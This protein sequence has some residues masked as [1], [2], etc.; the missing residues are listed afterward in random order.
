MPERLIARPF[1][2]PPTAELR[3]LP[4]CPRQLRD[5]RLGWVAI[6]HG[7]EST[8]GSF[9][10]LDLSTLE[11]RTFPLPGRPGFFVETEE[12]DVLLIGLERR[13][14]LFDWKSG[15]V[16]RT[17][18]AIPDDPQVIINDGIAV[19]DGVIFGT[20]HLMFNRPVAALY[21][22]GSELRELIGEQTCSN[23]KYFHDDLLIDVDTQPKTI[24]EYRYRSDGPLEKLRFVVPPEQL[25]ALPDG[26]RATADGEYIVVAFYNPAMVADGI[27]QQIRIADG[28]VVAEWSVPG[29][30]RVTCPA[31]VEIGGER[32]W[33]FTTAVE[34]MK[35]E[36][37]QA[38][39]FFVADV[40]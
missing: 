17:I 39:T 27:V 8:I 4:E 7:P 30:P 12:P 35:P 34:G 11:N 1:F 23:G 14:V 18:A 16:T 33:L 24:T 38:G 13:L 28:E 3:H 2:R 21:H 36:S 5:G 10:V 9:N 15:C 32:Q 19:P 26:L 22:Y 31:L 20:K 25:P 37:P 6:Q 40:V 29:S